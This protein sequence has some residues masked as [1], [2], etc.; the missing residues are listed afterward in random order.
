MKRI[1]N[2]ATS[3]SEALEWDIEQN[4]TMS[5]EERQ[6]ASKIL[7]IRVY[8]KNTPDIRESGVVKVIKPKK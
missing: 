7:K 4:F 1:C 6:K 5:V 8:G 3:H 2:K